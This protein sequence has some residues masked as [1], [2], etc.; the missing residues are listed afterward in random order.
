M[1]ANRNA[2]KPAVVIKVAPGG[3]YEFVKRVQP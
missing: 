2:Q 1:D 3:R